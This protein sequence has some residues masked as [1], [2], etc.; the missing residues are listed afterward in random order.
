MKF[1]KYFSL[2]FAIIFIV[3][4]LVYWVLNVE[5]NMWQII[6]S[7]TVAGAIIAGTLVWMGD[8]RR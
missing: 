4:L 1:L 7:A 8:R 2:E 6:F 3:S 5:Y